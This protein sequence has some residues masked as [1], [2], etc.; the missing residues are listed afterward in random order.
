M[1]RTILI[2][3]DGA[4]FSILDALIAEGHMPRLRTFIAQ[5]VRAELL[6]TPNPL[7]PPAWTTLMTG[8]GPGSHG[9][10]DFI[11]TEERGNEVYFTLNNFRDIQVETIWAMVSRQSGRV[12]TLNFPLMMPP[13]KIAGSVVPGL[14][15]WRHLRR[16]VHPPELYAQLKSL[17]GFDV[18]AVAWDFD[19]EKRATQIIPENEREEWITFH[20]RREQQWFEIFR[21]LVRNDPCDLTAILIDG[22][23]KLQHICWGQL[24]PQYSDNHSTPAGGRNRQLCLEYFRNLD[25]FLGEVMEW[26]GPEARVFIASDHGFGPTEKVFRVNRWLSERGYLAWAPTAKLDPRERQKVDNLVT[27]HFVYLDWKNTIAY[28]PSPALN[29]IHIRVAGD[30][31][32][33]GIPEWEYEAFRNRLIAELYEIRDPDTGAPVVA[34]VLK[35]EDTFPGAHGHHG[36]D[37]T[38]VLHDHG[39]VSTLNKEPVIWARPEVAGTHRP[40]GIFLARGAGIPR[41]QVIGQQ[42]IMDVAPTLLYSLGLAIPEDLEGRVITEAF[43]AAHRRAHPVQPGPPTQAPKTYVSTTARTPASRDEEAEIL[44]RLQALGY[45][46]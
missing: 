18:K 3:L 11:W 1:Q 46:E 40:E 34:H 39:F 26:A 36:P 35:K 41:G 15:S 43:D 42:S 31:N 29:G 44:R 23:D 17:P 4:T 5:G 28:A 24:D 37:L 2:G 30:A 14:V 10:F 13:P 19:Q 27:G 6:S 33:G 22:V 7:T 21:H 38:L 12:T 32:P 25:V 9:I 20:L 45:M 8:R 16:N